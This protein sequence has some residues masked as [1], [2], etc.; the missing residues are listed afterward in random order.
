MIH[1]EAKT[2]KSYPI[3]DM[4]DEHLL[5]TVQLFYNRLVIINKTIEHNPRYLQS[6][7]KIIESLSLYYFFADM[8][9]LLDIVTKNKIQTA[10]EEYRRFRKSICSEF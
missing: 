10:Y 5:R 3:T 2:G 6:V 4:T 1:I 7:E 8:N 9:D